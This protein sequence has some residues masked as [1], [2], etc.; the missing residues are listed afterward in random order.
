MDLQKLQGCRRQED[1]L[2]ECYIY[3]SLG[4]SIDT[5]RERLQAETAHEREERQQHD[6]QNQRHIIH[7]HQNYIM[8]IY[9][10]II[11]VLYTSLD[12]RLVSMVPGLPRSVCV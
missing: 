8:Y 6:R 4:S 2:Q 10:S 9:L 7:V 11:P 1:Q 5:K 3:I 12:S